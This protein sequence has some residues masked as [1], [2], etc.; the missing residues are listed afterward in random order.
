MRTVRD[1]LQRKGT[2]VWAVSPETTVIDALK[3]MADKNIGAVLV[4]DEDRVVGV[5]SERDYAR[6]VVLQGRTS[7]DTVARQ[8]MSGRV[9]GVEPQQTVEE[10]MALMTDKRIR[11][12]PVVEGGEVIGVVS[13]GDIVK[14]IISEQE[15]LIEQLEHYIT[16]TPYRL[17]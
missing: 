14:N 9:V 15:F 13:I 4:L 6:K 17:D 7:Q 12:L 10:C 5:L 16:G 11:H 3:L 1:I 2:E 8:I